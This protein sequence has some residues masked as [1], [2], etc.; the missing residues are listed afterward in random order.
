MLGGVG[1]FRGVGLRVLASCVAP[2][3][4]R[5]VGLWPRVLAI[6]MCNG[7]FGT[8]VAHKNWRA[9]FAANFALIL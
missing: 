3:R 9:S 8:V 7:S 6:L 4:L 1:W 5:C 2:S